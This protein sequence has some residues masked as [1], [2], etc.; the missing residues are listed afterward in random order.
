M[1][2]ETQNVLFAT[3]VALTFTSSLPGWQALLAPTY[4]A[5]TTFVRASNIGWY[6]RDRPSPP[7]SA[8]NTCAAAKLQSNA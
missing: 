2:S 4:V 7:R 5:S 1:F 6:A 3:V 8:R